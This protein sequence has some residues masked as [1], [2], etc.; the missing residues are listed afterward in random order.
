M[1]ALA[2]ALTV[3]AW[4]GHINLQATV[5]IALF[6]GV[7][8]LFSIV[9][10][11]W[12]KRMLGALVFLAP[13]LFAGHK[14]PGFQAL[15]I[16]DGILVSPDAPRYHFHVNLDYVSVGIVLMGIFCNPAL[17]RKLHRRSVYL[18]AAIMASAIVLVFGLATAVGYVRPEWNWPRFAPWILASN[19]FFVCVTEEAY[20]RGFIFAGLERSM[21]ARRFGRFI[22]ALVSAC[23]FGY[24]HHKGGMVLVGLAI[25]A[26]LHYTLSYIVSRRIECAIATHFVFNAVHFIAFTYPNLIA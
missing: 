4:F 19:L 26:G 25:L 23:L 5:W 20:F 22:A 13:L 6:A 1:P 7:C 18:V 2:G 21:K 10:R 15:S 8:F 11:P 24:A 16:A 9:K 17:A 12:L 14:F 3:S